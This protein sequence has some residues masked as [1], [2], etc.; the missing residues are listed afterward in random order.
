MCFVAWSTYRVP[1]GHTPSLVELRNDSVEIAVK[2]VARNVI[3]LLAP[4]EVSSKGSENH[5]R[6]TSSL[7]QRECHWTL[8]G[9]VWP[10]TRY[11]ILPQRH[12]VALGAYVQRPRALSPEFAHWARLVLADLYRFRA[13]NKLIHSPRKVPCDP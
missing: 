12:G 9:L 5:P 13:S 6:V 1:V 2:R 3:T 4:V 11:V 7:A 8:I 10:C